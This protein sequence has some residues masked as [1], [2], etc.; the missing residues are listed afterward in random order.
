MDTRSK[1]LNVDGPWP[2]FPRPL[3]VITGYFD[4]LRAA[5]VREL[6]AARLAAGAATLLVVVMPRERELL[7]L[8]ARAEMVAALRL[9]DYVLCGT[10]IE[11]LR[12]DSVTMLEESDER[13]LRDL[14]VSAAGPSGSTANK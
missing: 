3:A 1:I 11:A 4:V 6:E 14:R 12:P 2:D 9:V 5:H 7:P 8:R 13:R 10:P